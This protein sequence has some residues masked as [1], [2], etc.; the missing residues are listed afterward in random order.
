M[1][2][3]MMTL[4]QAVELVLYAFAHGTNGD[5]FVQK[6]PACTVSTLAQALLHLMRRPGHQIV[7]IGT[8]HGEKVYEVLLSREERAHAE[9]LGDY[10]RVRPDGRDLNYAKF[11]DQGE[12]QITHAEEYT[13][14]NTRRLE[15]NEVTQLLEK[16]DFI[17]RV[18]R[19]EVATP[20]Q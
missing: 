10:Y 20:E 17:Q 7:E 15:V 6:A 8:R 16:L 14:H 2:R 3:F 9:D 18:V 12:R 11:F 13:S 5:L 4:E 1:T 19:G